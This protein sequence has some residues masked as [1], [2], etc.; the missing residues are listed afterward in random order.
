MNAS[1]V[2]ALTIVIIGF[3]YCMFSRRGTWW[4][5]RS[6]R[7]NMLEIPR[8]NLYSSPLVVGKLMY[9]ASQILHDN[10][11]RLGVGTS[12]CER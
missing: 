1:K 6:L 3:A 9:A 2:H 12:V 4:G 11:V 8:H 10:H 7:P 5:F